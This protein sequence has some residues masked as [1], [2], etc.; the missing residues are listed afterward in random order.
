MR[1]L[2]LDLD[3]TIRETKSGKAFIND[4]PTDQQLIDGAAEAIA[5]YDKLGWLLVGVSNQGG[6]AAGK[7]TIKDAISEQAITLK[8]AGLDAIYFC[9]NYHGVECLKVN[10]HG[11]ETIRQDSVAQYGSF[12]KPGPGMFNLAISEFGADRTDCWMVGDRPEDQEAAI[13][14]GVKFCPD[15]AWRASRTGIQ[16]HSITPEQLDFVEGSYL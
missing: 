11:V 5:R 16:S 1:I 12:R 6:V 7:K 10:A 4:D 3:G 15:S 9:P 2:F 8:L 13:N 14:A